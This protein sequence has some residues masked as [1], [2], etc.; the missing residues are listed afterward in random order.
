MLFGTSTNKWR[1][2]ANKRVEASVNSPASFWAS[3]RR[4]TLFV[5]PNHCEAKMRHCT[6]T[7]LPHF[8]IALIFLVTT[9][10]IV[11]A[12]ELL[13]QVRSFYKD[14]IYVTQGGGEPE[15]LGTFSLRVLR[16]QPP[17]FIDGFIKLRNGYIAGWWLADTTQANTK[18]IIWIR[19]CGS[20]EIGALEVYEFD[21][22]KLKEASIPEPPR[23]FMEGYRG[24][25]GYRLDDNGLVRTFSKYAPDDPNSSPTGGTVVI[26]YLFSQ[27]KWIRSNN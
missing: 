16:D 20:G 4:L 26:K 13:P 10:P 6:T 27:K 12:A 17:F 19:S 14:M 23:D 15:C 2:G 1:T 22:K 18:I 3:A 11:H 8:S 21:G 25:D 7:L 5:R 24:Q 9:I